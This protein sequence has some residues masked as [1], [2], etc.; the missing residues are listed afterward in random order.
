M[1]SIKVSNEKGITL[2]T[3][4]VTIIIILI[5]AGITIAMLTGDNG[6]IKKSL[7]ARD[8][9]NDAQE[10]EMVQ[11][12]VQSAL[13]DGEGIINKKDLAKELNVKENELE[14]NNNS[15]IYVSKNKNYYYI[16]YLGDIVKSKGIAYS[17]IKVG[18]TVSGY[19][20]S[21]R[22]NNN[23]IKEWKVYYVDELNKYI[24][25][26]STNITE[27]DNLVNPTPK[28]TNL[29]GDGLEKYLGTQQLQ[30]V[31]YGNR[32]RAAL[33]GLLNVVTNSDER[34]VANVSTIGV[35]RMEY[36]LDSYNWK[37]YVSPNALWAIGGPTA[38]LLDMSLEQEASQT[39]VDSAR[40]ESKWVD[41]TNASGYSLISKGN[42]SETSVSRTSEQYFIATSLA[43]QNPIWA[44]CLYTYGTQ[45]SNQV[46]YNQYGFRPVVC[47]QQGISLYDDGNGGY[48]L[49]EKN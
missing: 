46:G 10:L 25:L 11:V 31:Q 38:E 44:Q 1:K 7:E 12:A 17:N 14:E 48:T 39:G 30:S 29:A 32:F 37:S 15:W 4:V 40:I 34:P 24:Y 47:L 6:I 13:V 20:G 28:I 35:K 23:Q 19:I 36:M 8:V 45:I 43:N 3:L 26:I 27:S 21:T 5:L 18:K 49:N 22:D 42:L 16:S 9:N 41:Y 2:V 33:A